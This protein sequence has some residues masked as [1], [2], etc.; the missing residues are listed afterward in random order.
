V[1]LRERA[2][3]ESEGERADESALAGLCAD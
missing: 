2:A 1:G 3:G